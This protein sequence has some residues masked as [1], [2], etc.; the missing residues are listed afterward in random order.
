MQMT[1]SK[2]DFNYLDA[3]KKE[4]RVILTVGPE[5]EPLGIYRIEVHGDMPKDIAS[6]IVVTTQSQ[7][8]RKLESFYKEACKSNSQVDTTIESVSVE[9]IISNI[10]DIG[11]AF[12]GPTTCDKPGVN[13]YNNI[14]HAPGKGLYLA[15]VNSYGL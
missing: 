7:L 3:I 4:G 9:C 5:H 11:L 10:F 14:C 15:A 1:I 13:A 8:F 12:V 2:K 6:H